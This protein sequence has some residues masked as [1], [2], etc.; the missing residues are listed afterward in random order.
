MQRRIETNSSSQMPRS[1]CAMWSTK[2]I[3]LSALS[4]PG[5]G[6]LL[7]C[8]DRH[9]LMNDF[10]PYPLSSMLYLVQV[11]VQVLDGCS[12]ERLE[13]PH[14]FGA[15]LVN[16][17]VNSSKR[18]PPNLLFDNVLIDSVDCCTVILAI[19]V[20]GASVEGLFY[21]TGCGRLPAMMSQRALVSRRRPECYGERLAVH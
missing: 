12:T 3:G 15:M 4:Q 8:L 16:R 14:I 13:V 7:H 1:P 17:Q 19:G 5:L 10:T 6:K 2:N 21:S 9:V 11:Q 18:S 20:L